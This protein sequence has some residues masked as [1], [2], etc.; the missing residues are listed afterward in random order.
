[1]KK[2]ILITAV[3]ML[4]IG[5]TDAEKAKFYGLGN[6]FKITLYSGGKPV[7]EWESTGKVS[8]EEKSDGYYF[9]DQATGKVVEVCGD[10]VIERID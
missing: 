4:A 6:R 1:M 5:C 10:V 9:M 3:C 7:R 8:S 2:L